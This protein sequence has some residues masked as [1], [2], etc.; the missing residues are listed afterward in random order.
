MGGEVKGLIDLNGR[1][2]IDRV[3][4]VAAP[5][6]SALA[7]NANGDPTA[8]AAFGLPVI[9]D[10][11][12]G[13]VGPLAGVLAGLRW[14][15][16]HHPAATDIATFPCDAPFLPDVCVARLEAARAAVP[17]T[18]IALASSGGKLHPVVGLW[19]VALADDLEAALADGVRKVLHWTDRHGVAEAEFPIKLVGGEPVDPFFNANTPDDIAEARRRLSE[20]AT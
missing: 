15:E 18:R 20:A 6:V 16:T 2:M 11:V 13:F 17:A 12:A 3:I 9:P 1:T 19:P 14:A 7:I 8:F 10:P 5:Q 4:D